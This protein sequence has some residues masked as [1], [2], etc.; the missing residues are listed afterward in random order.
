MDIKDRLGAPARLQAEMRAPVP[1]QVELHIAAAPVKLE[2]ALAL[3]VRRVLAPLNDGQVGLQKAIGHALHHGKAAVGAQFL[4]IVKEHAA[5]AA[6][7]LP[8]LEVEILVAPLLEARVFVVA[9]RRQ[10]VLAGL[11]EMHR[12]FFKAV[13]RRQVHAAAEPADGR[14][15]ADAGAAASMRTFMCTVGT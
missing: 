13:I 5:Y 10:R 15:G 6:L 12:V 7:L 11:V 2:F 1:D 14:V 9:E 4:E 8:V 3:A